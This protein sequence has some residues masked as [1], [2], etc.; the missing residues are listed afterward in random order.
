MFKEP[1]LAWLDSS[2]MARAHKNGLLNSEVLSILE[3]VAF[4]HHAVDDTPYGGGPGELMKISIIEPL[5]RD[6]L[7]KNPGVARAKKRVLLMDPAGITFT[8]DHAKRL[9]G[10]DEL[11]FISG[12]YEGIDAR[13]H[14]YI[15]EAVSIGDFVLSSGDIAAMAIFD[16][17]ARMIEGFLGN[18]QSKVLDS[19]FDGRL[20]ASLY[21][22]PK[23][24]DGH[25]VPEV[26]CGGNHQAINKALMLE[27]LHKTSLMRPDLINK[28]P[29][30]DAEQ[31][32]LKANKNKLL[33]YP[34]MKSHE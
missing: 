2:I 27:S 28:H 3:H 32:L 21:T 17:T 4:D 14:H 34:W 30:N 7:A 23:L 16:A 11:I 10:Y 19:H 13:V 5:I 15:D 20:E 24:Y 26:F 8:Q 12:R 29:L 18:S 33:S 31:A 9:S 25:E 6:A 22:R 1:L